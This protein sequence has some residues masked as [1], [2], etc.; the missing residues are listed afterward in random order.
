MVIFAAW[1]PRK[2]FSRL[3]QCVACYITLHHCD[4]WQISF[5]I[6]YF[7]YS[8]P[9]QDPIVRTAQRFLSLRERDTSHFLRIFFSSFLQKEIK[10]CWVLLITTRPASPR[11]P[12]KSR[13]VLKRLSVFGAKCAPVLCIFFFKGFSAPASP[14]AL[15][16]LF[17]LIYVRRDVLCD[18]L[19]VSGSTQNQDWWSERYSSQKG[20]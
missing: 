15:G 10:A 6:F 2:Q 17:S 9:P 3:A 7:F 13:P 19:S 5:I 12:Q 20:V 18:N 11:H 14:R 8:P 4:R 1:R 16:V